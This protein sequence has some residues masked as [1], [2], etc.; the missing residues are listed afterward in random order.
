M[1]P[2]EVEYLIPNGEQEETQKDL[3]LEELLMTVG[4]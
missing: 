1:R 4:F 2:I 3:T